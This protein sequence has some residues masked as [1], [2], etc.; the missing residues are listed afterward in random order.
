MIEYIQSRNL[1]DRTL[2]L[3]DY[4]R[5]AFEDVAE[6]YPIIGDVRGALGS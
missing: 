3:G 5:R 1:L 6:R 4:A 2:Q